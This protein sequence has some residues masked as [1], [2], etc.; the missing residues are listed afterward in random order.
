M[1]KPGKRTRLSGKPARRNVAAVVAR[2][3]DN[4]VRADADEPARRDDHQLLRLALHELR[5][6]LTSVQLNGQLLERALGRPGLEKERRL[7][8]MIVSSARKL[9]F[10]TQDLADVAHPQ[11]G[12]RTADAW[13]HDLARL[14]PGML[15]RLGLD[16]SRVHLEM[17]PSPVP[18]LADARRLERIL[19]NLFSVGLRHA[20]SQAGI[21]LRVS[22]DGREVGFDVIVPM[23]P[24]AARSTGL[25]LVVARAMIEAHGRKL[26]SR[27]EPTGALVLH[28]SLPTSACA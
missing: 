6:P 20:P 2:R 16:A 15:V 1:A 25:G 18:I 4:D 13:A 9:D 5:N 17:P 23:R 11:A 26:E 22:T 19:A 24:D 7:A 10:L 21:E 27:Q 3:R 14:L 8:G 12:Q 28:F